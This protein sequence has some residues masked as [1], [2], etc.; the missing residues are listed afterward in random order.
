ML[1]GLPF[2]PF[3]LFDDGWHPAE[4]GIGGRHDLVPLSV[5][6][7]FLDEQACPRST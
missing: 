6:S 1:D 7:L 2:D 4:V 3:T 5:K